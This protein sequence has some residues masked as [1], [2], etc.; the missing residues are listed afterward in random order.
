LV[1]AKE[2]TKNGGFIFMFMKVRISGT[3]GSRFCPYNRLDVLYQAFEENFIDGN[4]GRANFV[5]LYEA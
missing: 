4:T 1:K 3:H 2:A 5:K